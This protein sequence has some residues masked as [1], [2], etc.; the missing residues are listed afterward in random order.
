MLKRYPNNPTFGRKT[1]DIDEGI[2]LIRNPPK[3]PCLKVQRP[4]YFSIAIKYKRLN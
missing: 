4:P 2:L 3:Q 1:R